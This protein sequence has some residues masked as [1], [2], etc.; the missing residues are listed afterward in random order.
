MEENKLLLSEF[1]NEDGFDLNT[2]LTHLFD[3]LS[4]DTG[5]GT[6]SH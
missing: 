2:Y 3:Y 5:T 1:A 4:R 6:A